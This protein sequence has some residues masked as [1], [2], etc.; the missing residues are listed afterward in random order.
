MFFAIFVLLYI[1]TFI[2]FSTKPISRL[3]QKDKI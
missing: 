2:S 1:Y 3:V